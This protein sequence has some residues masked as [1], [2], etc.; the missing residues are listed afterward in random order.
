[1]GRDIAAA[2]QRD[3][4]RRRERKFNKLAISSGSEGRF[5]MQE[6]EL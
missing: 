1:L 3:Q 6:M 4:L 2:S 5:V